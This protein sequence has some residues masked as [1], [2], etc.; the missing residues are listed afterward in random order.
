MNRKVQSV[1]RNAGSILLAGAVLLGCQPAKDDPKAKGGKQAGPSG[2]PRAVQAV[3]SQMQSVERTVAAVGSL[4][5]YEQATMSVKVAG[6][7]QEVAIDL[8]AV[9]KKGQVIAKLEPREYEVKLQQS[10][11]L[12]AQARARLGLPL[13]NSDDKVDPAKTSVVREAAAVMQEA[14]RNLDRIVKLS[15]QGVS[16]QSELEAVESAYE[17]ALSR[18]K[19]A[20]EEIRNRQALLAQRLAEVA[21]ARQQLEETNIKA[22]FDGIVQE[23]KANIGEY[24]II[25]APVATVVRTDVLRLRLEVPERSA[26]LIKEGHAVRLM[27]TGDTNV[28]KGEIRRLSPMLNELSRMLVVEA[29][30]PNPGR[31]RPGFFAQ[32]DIVVNANEPALTVPLDS[33]VVFAG[34]EKV[35]SIKE[36]KA[37]ERP[38]KTGRKGSNW[39]EIVSGLKAGEPVIRNP[40]NLRTGDLISTKES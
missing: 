24:L 25:G 34:V 9:V 1:L 10:E 33:L 4:A 23:R 11:A 5:A 13:E 14:K 28:Y 7:M 40:G 26:A 17:V 37:H 22:P 32:A 21:I 29:D 39:V 15:K 12:L 19:D 2:P 20:L 3:K 38:I 31:L 35:I 6:R 30:V 8:G 27:V 16:S 36:G 18:H